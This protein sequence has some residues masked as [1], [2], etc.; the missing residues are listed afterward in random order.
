MLPVP[1]RVLTMRHKLPLLQD[2]GGPASKAKWSEANWLMLSR[3]AEQG[4]FIIKFRR[5]NTLVYE[6]EQLINCVM[7]RSEQ[8][9]FS[10]SFSLLFS[11]ML[12]QRQLNLC[13]YQVQ[14]W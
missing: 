4:G 6:P 9:D 3:E 12:I 10:E 1:S 11:N 8:D 2:S 7:W 14:A 13:C 5:Q